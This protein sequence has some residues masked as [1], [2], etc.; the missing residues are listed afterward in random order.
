MTASLPV[1]DAMQTPD[2]YVEQLS[3]TTGMPHVLVRKNMTKISGVMAEMGSV[4]AGLTRGLETSILDQGYGDTMVTPSVL[5][6]NQL[7]GVILRKQ[8]ARCSFAL[9]SVD[10]DE[11]PAGTQAREC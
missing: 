1:G 9:D 4:L 3:A 8:L 11:D 10:C 5:P 6:A 2:D 7:A